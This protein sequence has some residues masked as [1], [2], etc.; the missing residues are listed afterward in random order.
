MHKIE[1][2]PLTGVEREFNENELIVSKTDL[3]GKLTYG[4]RLFFNLA[5][6][7]EEECLGKQHNIVRHPD[8]PRCVFDLLWRT[9]Q[10]GEELFAYVV[11]RSSNG[12]H[13]W[14]FAHVTPSTD[15][16]GTVNGY[17]SNRRSPNRTIL[18]ESIIPLYKRLLRVE[19]DDPSPRSGLEKS[20]AMIADL[21][22][23]RKQ[24]FNEFMFSLE[25]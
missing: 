11:N 22:A 1:I 17:H 24:G 8:M 12:D 15:M 10:A 20:K 5:G 21:L 25:G 19:K 3:T 4:N 13:Y 7:N 6:M 18:N 2:I 14:V 16:N 9:L 23:E